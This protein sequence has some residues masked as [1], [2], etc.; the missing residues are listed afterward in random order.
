[1]DHE[2]HV[3]EQYPLS[4]LVALDVCR[5]RAC[6]CESLLYFIRDG[7]NLPRVATRTDHEVVGKAAR[8]LVE[9]QNG[10]AFSLF[11]LGGGQG[12]E[13]L[14]LRFGLLCSCAH[15]PL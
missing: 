2:I 10:K 11:A 4:L 9:F 5:T 1:M 7:L 6:L 13:N 3:V 12:L 15:I 14:L 8:R